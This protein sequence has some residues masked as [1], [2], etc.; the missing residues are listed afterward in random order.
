VH[1]SIIILSITFQINII[2]QVLIV[3]SL[4]PLMSSSIYLPALGNNSAPVLI[5]VIS[6][7][8]IQRLSTKPHKWLRYVLFAICGVRGDISL[9]ANGPP[10]NYDS[11]VLANDYYFTP[12]GR[13]YGLRVCSFLIPSS[14]RRISFYRL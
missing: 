7:A 12:Q 14:P 4:S 6:F 3:Q 9:T 10:V 5:L 8:D 2:T 1:S 11:D 13:L